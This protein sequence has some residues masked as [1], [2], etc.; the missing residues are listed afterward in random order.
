MPRADDK[1]KRPTKESVHVSSFDDT[2]KKAA[3]RFEGEK[4]K[5]S[6]YE[7]TLCK[8]LDPENELSIDP[9]IRLWFLCVPHLVWEDMKSLQ[10]KK[11]F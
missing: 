1:L 8:Y 3:V 2:E 7:I 11:V 5:V 9:I 4:I 10:D 6:I